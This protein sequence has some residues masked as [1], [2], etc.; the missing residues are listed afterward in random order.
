[1]TSTA[2]ENTDLTKEQRA[3]IIASK[4]QRAIDWSKNAYRLPDDWPPRKRKEHL[5]KDSWDENPEH[6]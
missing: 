1:M 4:V 2:S 6:G 3:A 5:C